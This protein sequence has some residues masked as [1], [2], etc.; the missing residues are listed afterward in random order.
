MVRV[1]PHQQHHVH[2]GLEQL[3]ELRELVRQVQLLEVAVQRLQEQHVV[4]RLH[5]RRRHLFAQAVKRGVVARLGHLQHF[6]NLAD[7]QPAELLVDRVEVRR[8][9]LPELQLRQRAGVKPLLQRRRR[10]GLLHHS[11]GVSDWLHGPHAGCHQLDVIF[12]TAK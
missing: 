8:L 2:D 12:L 11:R 10:L 7:L 3:H 1:L 4:V 6:H 5:A 9:V